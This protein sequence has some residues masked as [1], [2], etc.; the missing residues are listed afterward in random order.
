MPE[1][2]AQLAVSAGSLITQRSRVQIPPPQIHLSSK[3][4]SHSAGCL[5]YGRASRWKTRNHMYTSGTLTLAVNCGHLR[6]GA[7]R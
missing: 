6:S 1:P 5:L 4:A 3:S 2:L 7:S